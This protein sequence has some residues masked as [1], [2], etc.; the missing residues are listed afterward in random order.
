MVENYYDQFLGEENPI[1]NESAQ[2]ESDLEWIEFH[3]TARKAF[4]EINSLKK[5]K[6]RYIKGHTR[7]SHFK[8]KSLWHISKA[9]VAERVG[10]KPQP[11]FNSNK[12][13]EGLTKYYV[14]V[15]KDLE[16][17]VE[18]QIGKEKKGLQHRSKSELKESTKDLSQKLD[19]IQEA[20]CEQLF[21]KL[22]EEMPFDIRRKLGL[23]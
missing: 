8:T 22:L 10:V 14:K 13:S 17:Q 6:L 19:S 4:E 1:E 21:Q 15:V 12:F 16:N 2:V 23:V 5:I 11:L 18:K 3:P 7:K 20:N 9:E